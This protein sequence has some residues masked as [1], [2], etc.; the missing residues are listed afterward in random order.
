[1]TFDECFERL[2][3]HEGGYTDN[4]KDPGNWTGGRVGVGLLKGTK[5][6]IAANSYPDEDIK[7]LTL[8]RAKDIYKRDYWARVRCDDLP[9]AL[10]Y[11][12]FDATVNSGANQ[13]VKWLQRAVGVTADGIIGPATLAAV[14]K[15][16][17]I[18]LR[19]AMLGQ[20]LRFMTDLPA[21]ASFGRGWAR[22]IASL[23]GV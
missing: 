8:D 2:L 20:R 9:A 3:G 7:N 14:A 18:T 16:D 21:W 12:M 19:Q 22:R 1:M 13:A 5:Y 10:R 15:C 17:P 4:P 11:P 6:G 23:L